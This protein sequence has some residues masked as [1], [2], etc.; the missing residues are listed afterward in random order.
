Q[1]FQQVLDKDPNNSDALYNLG[2]LSEQRGDLD[3]A[4]SRYR[5]ALRLN[6]QD[7]QLKG[8]VEEIS[9]ELERRRLEAEAHAQVAEARAQAAE[10][11]AQAAQ[12]QTQAAEERAR[13]DRQFALQAQKD[14]RESQRISEP[15]APMMMAFPLIRFSSAGRVA[16]NTTGLGLG[17][18]GSV[19]R[20]AAGFGLT[21][22]RIGLTLAAIHCPKCRVRFAPVLRMLNGMP[23]IR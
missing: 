14:R 9:L 21:G 2:A 15:R 18:G 3:G 7:P 17:G 1:V 19:V 10:A 4:L 13:A 22:T 12:A 11:Q 8:T 23:S 20:R 5:G 6:P 16:R